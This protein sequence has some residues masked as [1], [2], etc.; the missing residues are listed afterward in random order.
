MSTVVNIWSGSK[1]FIKVVLKPKWVLVLGQL[2]WTFLIH[3]KCWLLYIVPYVL[4]IIY[5]YNIDNE[6]CTNM[7]EIKR[8]IIWRY[9]PVEHVS[10]NSL[11][12]SQI[13]GRQQK[14]SVSRNVIYLWS[15]VGKFENLDVK[16][17]SVLGEHNNHTHDVYSLLSRFGRF[18]TV[19]LH[20]ETEIH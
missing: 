14:W 15:S 6:T 10:L 18:L 5:I 9:T 8:K 7:F 2:W 19:N 12:S 3:F 17:L 13:I 1:P 16:V 11:Q 4:V 20:K